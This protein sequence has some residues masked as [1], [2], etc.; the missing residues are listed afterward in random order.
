M[1]CFP[2]CFTSSNSRKHRK[3]VA[4]TP[5][6]QNQDQI[7]E[8][9]EE[10]AVLFEPT[11][12]DDIIKPINP[13]TESKEV[14][15]EQTKNDVKRKVTFDLEEEG[16]AEK[17]NENKEETPKEIE[18][19]LGSIGSSVV[20]VVPSYPSNH[21]YE[22][23]SNSEDE[24][25]GVI[26]LSGSDL[27]GDDSGE[28]VDDEV[29]SNKQSVIQEQE[30]SESLFSISID[31]RTKQSDAEE[32]EKE[33]NSPM[34]KPKP[35]ESDQSGRDNSNRSQHCHSVLSPIENLSQWKEVK[36]KAIPLASNHQ[37]KENMNAEQDFN[38][39][40]SPEP[41]LK[42]SKH[43]RRRPLG[44]NDLKLVD[45]EN[46]VDTS[47]SSWL[48]ECETTPKS[49]ASENSVGNLMCEGVSSSRRLGDRPILG[50]WTSEELKQLSNSSTLNQSRSPSPDQI[51]I[52]GTVGS[53][54][55]H[56][57]QATN[58]DS[59]SSS[60]G[61]ENKAGRNREDEKVKWKTIPFEAK[62][63]RVLDMGILGA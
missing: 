5:S 17:Q 12:L 1:G 53:Y 47:L 48:V 11:K 4:V 33:V 24:D 44:C 42:L 59:N 14:I 63:E 36:A 58:S 31:S 9:T 16:I 30:S 52:I 38:I 19:I 27:N 6:I 2:A 49:N 26:D 51:P 57:G 29:E 10:E 34:P 61:M 15:E 32:D 60:R 25:E 21:R 13:I 62:L 8:A 55:S 37:E 56:T 46:G 35:I 50:A 18:P 54:W 3:S 43:F 40:I 45:Q 39:P 23:Y 41:T 22:N 7:V 28:S 20:T